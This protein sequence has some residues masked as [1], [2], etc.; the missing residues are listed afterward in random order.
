METYDEKIEKMEKAVDAL[1]QA[2]S[3]LNAS[4]LYG[5]LADTKKIIEDIEA[6]LDR[7]YAAK[8]RSERRR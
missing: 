3:L 7:T 4:S 6:E 8:V 2:E 5:A 1:K